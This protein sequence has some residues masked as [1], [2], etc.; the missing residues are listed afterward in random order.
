MSRKSRAPRIFCTRVHTRETRRQVRCILWVCQCTFNVVC[1]FCVCMCDVWVVL[2]TRTSRLHNEW[3][4]RDEWHT[5]FDTC[6]QIFAA[7]GPYIYMFN[8]WLWVAKEF[9]CAE[10]TKLPTISHPNRTGTGDR[11]WVHPLCERLVYNVCFRTS[12][13]MQSDYTHNKVRFLRPK[14]SY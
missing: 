1:V 11:D 2:F 6:A 10:H 13:P 5:M 9:E 14:S 4:A 3:D 8:G 12:R 7:P